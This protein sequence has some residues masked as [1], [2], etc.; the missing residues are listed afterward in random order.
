MKIVLINIFIFIINSY[1]LSDIA[2]FIIFECA[3]LKPCQKFILFFINIYCLPKYN[4]YKYSGSF[5][6]V[7]IMHL[8]TCPQFNPQPERSK[9]VNPI[10]MP[11]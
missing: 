6:S 5:Y 8:N 4:W 11:G 7:R 3:I 9:N 2:F 10:K 1:F